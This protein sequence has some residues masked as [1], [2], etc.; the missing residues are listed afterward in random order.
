MI[1]SQGGK[2]ADD[3]Y[4]LGHPAVPVYL[5]DGL[6]P[7]IFDAGL[8]MLGDLYIEEIDKILGD[9]QPAYCFLTHTH[10]DHCGAV[11]AFK[12]RY[13]Q[14]QVVAAKK[15]KEILQR[16]SAVDRIRFLNTVAE[17]LVKQ[18]GISYNS[19]RRFET[20]DVDRVVQE[21]HRVEV[22]ADCMVNVIESPGHTWDCL[23]YLVVGKSILLSSEAAGQADRTGYIVSDCLADYDRYLESLLKLK[24]LEADILCPGHL[25]VYSGADTVDYLERAQAACIDFRRMVET[26]TEAAG[27]QQS[28]I[29]RKIKAVEYDSN[30]GPKQPEPAYLINLEA[31]IKAVLKAVR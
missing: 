5:L 18:T 7:V 27:G 28:E 1:Y 20:F 21:G 6:F 3:F 31:R 12:R 19:D 9:R 22:S 29:I 8:A 24:A 30:P 17:P 15:A 13:P 23:S 11:S 10:F 25:F 4:L 16:P 2:I 14:I 26:L